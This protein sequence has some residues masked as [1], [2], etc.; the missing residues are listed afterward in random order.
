ML[1]IGIVGKTLSD[2]YISVLENHPAYKFVGIFD[3]SFQFEYPKSISKELIFTSFAEISSQ[4]DT[5]VFPSTDK[6]YFPLVE[7]AVMQSKSIFLH[8]VYNYTFD[9]L[10]TLTKLSEE[11]QEII[12]IYH[13]LIYHDAF[14]AYRKK[15]SQPLLINC[16]LLGQKEMNL[17][18]Y[19]RNQISAILSLVNANI[20]KIT[21]N[22]ISSF[23][24]IPDIIK[25]RLDF[26]NGSITDIHI[27]SIEHKH[28]HVIKSYNYNS[29]FEIDFI[30][31]Q[32]N[33]CDRDDKHIQCFLPAKNTLH[34]LLLKQ[35][36]EFYYN[37]LNHTQPVNGIENQI[38]TQL[39]INKIKEKL[40]MCINL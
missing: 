16:E 11:A 4:C 5:I 26:S 28:S 15:C 10:E 27:N 20:K 24:E 2:I 37:V 14:L 30:N 39:V 21:P 33:S 36:N 7:S 34:H 40:R 3:P 6:I 13:P 12:Q 32:L 1:K 35:L 31:H 23:S 19:A 18:P 8:G 38:H 29:F 25:V 22:T 17:I 9:E